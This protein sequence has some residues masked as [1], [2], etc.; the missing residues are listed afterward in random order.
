MGPAT[1]S[2]CRSGPKQRVGWLLGQPRLRDA[3]AHGDAGHTSVTDCITA[4]NGQA[5]EATHR[6]A[7]R[8][9]EKQTSGRIAGHDGLALLRMHGPGHGGAGGSWV[10]LGQL[11]MASQK[12]T[13]TV[14]LLL[15]AHSWP[16]DGAQPRSAP[17]VQRAEEEVGHDIEMLVR[18]VAGGHWASAVHSTEPPAW[19]QDSGKVGG[20]LSATPAKQL[21]GGQL[22]P[23]SSSW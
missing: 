8:A 7:L 19:G 11:P 20:Q 12:G 23:G 3:G 2:G 4:S 16:T 10:W 5:A 1:H 17:G 15:D 14:P 6:V 18:G 22:T 21:G 13:H 9:V